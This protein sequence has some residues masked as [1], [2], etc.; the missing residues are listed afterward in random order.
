M[1]ARVV[2][3]VMLV[4][5]LVGCSSKP[6]VVV[7]VQATQLLNPIELE[8]GVN[9]I[10]VI[11]GATAKF[12]KV[13]KVD[14]TDGFQPHTDTY[15]LFSLTVDGKELPFRAI[16]RRDRPQVRF[17]EGDVLRGKLRRSREVEPCVKLTDFPSVVLTD[18]ETEAK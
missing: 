10:L 1:L 15:A 18:L 11:Q 14:W 8:D 9:K 3:A 12:V 6:A 16:S 13:M 17:N 5:A 2:L 4:G 7:Q